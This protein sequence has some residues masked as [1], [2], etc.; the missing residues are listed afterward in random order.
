MKKLG[1]I[2]C[3][4]A[5]GCSKDKVNTSDQGIAPGKISS[6]ESL[7]NIPF[8]QTD[9]IVVTFNGGTN[10]CAKPHHLEATRTGLSIS[11]NAYYYVPGHPII[12]PDYIPVHKLIYT[13]KPASKGIY[14][15]KSSGTNVS[16]T[17]IVN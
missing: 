7:N 2:I 9:T 13:F 6:I 4:L 16:A 3:F 8:G 15:Y 14:T 11:F 5:L 1:I 17:T 10:G 12:C